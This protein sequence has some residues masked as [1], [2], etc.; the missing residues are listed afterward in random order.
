MA[1]QRQALLD[2]MRQDI[3]TITEAE[4]EG[5]TATQLER[6]GFFDG[7][8]RVQ[9]APEQPSLLMRLASRFG[10]CPK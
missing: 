5:F 4:F 7:K 6:L 3:V 8:V 9:L 10:L 1:H 2:E